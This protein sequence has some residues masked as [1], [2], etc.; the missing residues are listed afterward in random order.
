MGATDDWS[1]SNSYTSGYIKLNS[2][3]NGG[4][5]FDT[6]GHSITFG[7]SLED[8]SETEIGS[9][10]KK[11]AGTLTLSGT[12][13][14]SGGTT[15]SA[16]T[17]VAANANALGTNAVE[18][19]GG[20]LEV[21]GVTL[22]QTAISI[23]LDNAYTSVAAIYGSGENAA[24]ANGT[25][26]T[27]SGDLDSLVTLRRA[28]SQQYE[29]QLLGSSLTTEGVTVTLSSALESAIKEKGWT[30]TLTDN[31]STLTL[32]IPEPSAFG[33]LAGVGALALCVSRRKR[34]K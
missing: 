34:R 24:L 28:V 17:L 23:V 31:G 12:N 7:A 15:I 2:T 20:Q 32:T 22:A 10:T 6:N 33:L 8:F 14:Y 11:G 19:S 4:A 27:V 29:Y 30:Y 13:T 21:S 18:I 16:G 25:T 26:I 9:L 5:K 3:E 1:V